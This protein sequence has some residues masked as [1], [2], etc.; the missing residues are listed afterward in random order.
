MTKRIDPRFTEHLFRPVYEVN[1][2][3][4]WAAGGVLTP[5]AAAIGTSISGLGLPLALGASMIGVSLYHANKA[6][7]LLKRQLS[8]TVNKKTFISSGELRKKNLVIKRFSN[9]LKK[10]PREVYMGTGFIWGSEHAQRAYQVMDMDS[11][12]SDVQLPYFLKPLVAA[13]Q[14]ETRELGGAPWIHGMGDEKP[15]SIVENTLYGHTFIA[16]NVGTGKTT[17]LKLMTINA[18]HLGNVL[19]VLDPKNDAAW[20]EA[21]KSEMDYMG[22]GDQFYHIHP[23]SPSTSARIPLLSKY[24]RITEIADRVAPLMGSSGSGKSFQD[25]AF[26]IITQTAGALKYLNEPIRLTSIQRVIASDR[27]GL[28]MRV[29]SKYY[30]E[31][32]GAGWEGRL[33]SVFDKMGNDRLEAMANYYKHTLSKE[34]GKQSNVVEDMIVFALHDEAH[35]SKMVVSLRP[36]LTALTAEPLDDLLSAVDTDDLD[37]PRPI[38]DLTTLMDKGGC[39]Y[40]S[41][42]SL[43]D[44]Q[45]AGYI[46]RLILAEIA[47]VAGDRYNRNEQNPR[48]VTVA[49]DEV[50]ASLENNQSLIGILAQGRAAAMQMILATQTVSDLEAKTDAATAKRF[51]GLCNNFISMRTTDPVTQ[52]YVAAQFST[53]SISQS[54]SQVAS[55]TG[56]DTSILTFQATHGERLMKT[57]EDAFPPV[58]LSQLP[59]LQYVARLADGRKLKMKLDILVNNDKP[60]ERAPWVS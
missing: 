47:A 10:D 42:D 54:Q 40:I 39:I 20:K 5:V 15:V 9:T 16:G 45:S 4:T 18:L 8:L 41:L 31:T 26:E 59:I 7:P 6:V 58:L 49:N 44:A 3:M 48:R 46:S 24:T 1:T 12:L 22:I 14:K 38:V 30:D 34:K 25:F 2:A 11:T 36:V 28:A 51:L 57:R 13:K 60:G 50:H 17:L 21:I 52:E 53:T 23:S 29:F 43:T 19:I 55:G 35:Y 27:K 33:Q 56:T 32:L 37:D